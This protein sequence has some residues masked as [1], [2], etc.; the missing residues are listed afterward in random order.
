MSKQNILI[1]EQTVYVG[2]TGT[3]TALLKEE[4]ETKTITLSM[5]N[6][7]GSRSLDLSAQEL[8]LLIEVLHNMKEKQS[9]SK[10]YR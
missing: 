7:E 8:A 2:L 1:F 5:A 3:I 4:N 9:S 10:H 6:L